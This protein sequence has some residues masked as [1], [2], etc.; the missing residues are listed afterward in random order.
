MR[1]LLEDFQRGL[2]C[3]GEG[4]CVVGILREKSFT[5]EE[6]SVGKGIFQGRNLEYRSY[7]K[8]D[9]KLN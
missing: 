4:G 6:C 1:N 5:F 3:P 2:N 7:L 9:E 8:N